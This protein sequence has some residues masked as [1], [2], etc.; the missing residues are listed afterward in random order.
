MKS[1]RGPAYRALFLALALGAAVLDGSAQGRGVGGRVSPDALRGRVTVLAFGGVLDPQSPEVLPV[2]QRVADRYERRGVAVFWVSID[3]E[4]SGAEG[5]VSDAELGGFAS[6]HGFR[7]TVL[8]DPTRD[9]LRAVNTG[10]R[11]QL[12]TFVVLD[13]SGRVVDRPISGFDRE[14]D[15]VNR[16]GQ[17]VDRLLEP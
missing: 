8:R 2:L 17:T 16:I 4:R 11:P 12:P 15:L 5:A 10:Q 7:G 1:T 14:A 6:R 13:A 9:A 3:P